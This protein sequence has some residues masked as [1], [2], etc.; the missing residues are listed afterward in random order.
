MRTN[1]GATLETSGTATDYRI[2]VSATTNACNAV[3]TLNHFAGRSAQLV[4][5]IASAN[6]VND[7]AANCAA[8]TTDGFLLFEDEI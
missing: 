8:A 1:N 2:N 3:P 4:F 6:L 5:G 7:E